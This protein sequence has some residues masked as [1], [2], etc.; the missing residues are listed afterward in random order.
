MVNF[1]ILALVG[2]I[3]AY[4]M[5]LPMDVSENQIHAGPHYTPIRSCTKR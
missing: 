4:T 3:Q 1:A 5:L 2:P